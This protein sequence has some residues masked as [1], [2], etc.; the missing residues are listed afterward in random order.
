MSNFIQRQI[1]FV[2]LLVTLVTACNGSAQDYRPAYPGPNLSKSVAVQ[3]SS[4]T[5]DLQTP[6]SAGEI[7]PLKDAPQPEVGKASIS[8]TLYSF[9]IFRVIP[10][11]FFYLTKATG[12]NNRDLPPA[13]IGPEQSRG[14]IIG[15]SDEKGQFFMTNIPP[16]NYFLVVSA[17][18]RWSF[19][20]V[21]DKDFAPL[22]IE[23][24]SNQKQP[25]GI[26]YVS[27]P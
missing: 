15:T 9:T 25:L 26:I 2:G 1:M 8:G 23:L 16:G 22:L 24:S 7:I 17:P 18:L 14:D 10:K 13:F 19:A 21:S 11:T 3:T 20:V 5:Y 6:Q 12:A 4:P 27:W